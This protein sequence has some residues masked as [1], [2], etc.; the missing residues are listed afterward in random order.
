M[1]THHCASHTCMAAE[2]A[3]AGVSRAQATGGRHLIDDVIVYRARALNRRRG[4]CQRRHRP[5][6]GLACRS[7]KLG[8]RL[9]SELVAEVAPR[10]IHGRLV[11]VQLVLRRPEA[12]VVRQHLRS[13]EC[14][15][16]PQ[17]GQRQVRARDVRRLHHRA[18]VSRECWTH[19]AR[20]PDL[21]WGQTSKLSS[22]KPNEM[23]TRG[24]GAWRQPAEPQCITRCENSTASPTAAGSA[25]TCWNASLSGS[26]TLNGSGAPSASASPVCTLTMHVAATPAGARAEAGYALHVAGVGGGGHTGRVAG[27]AAA[28]DD[29]EAA[30]VWGGVS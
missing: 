19:A 23:E 8:H 28:G 16:Q 4:L 30:G 7:H 10:C 5:L 6:V 9:A 14:E 22:E 24:C 13:H 21:Q 20:M 15:A 29:V 26:A 11:Q 12:L 3:R 25:R 18:V 27:V 2:Q 1:S 17:R